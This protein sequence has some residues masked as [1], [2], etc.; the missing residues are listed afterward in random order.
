MIHPCCF[1]KH[2]KLRKAGDKNGILERNEKVLETLDFCGMRCF[3]HAILGDL[4]GV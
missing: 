3:V 2:L 1:R 4:A